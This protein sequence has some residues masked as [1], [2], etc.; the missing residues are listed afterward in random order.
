MSESRR[1][2]RASDPPWVTHEPLQGASE[3]SEG[4]LD[5]A[6]PGPLLRHCPVSGTAPPGT[7]PR[8]VSTLGAP[9]QGCHEG[10]SLRPQPSHPLVGTS[11]GS[12]CAPQP[13]SPAGSFLVSDETDLSS[14]GSLTGLQFYVTQLCPL[15]LDVQLNLL[16]KNCWRGQPR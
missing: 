5:R 6:V 9:G 1:S 12:T 11:P 15:F 13:V 16:K 14:S 10:H 4:T 8:P 7:R 2:L 3:A